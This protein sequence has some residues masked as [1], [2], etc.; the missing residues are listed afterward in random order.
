M[1]Y[2]DIEDR[3]LPGNLRFL[4]TELLDTQKYFSK[5]IKEKVL[6]TTAKVTRYSLHTAADS[7]FFTRACACVCVSAG[8]KGT[9]L[10]L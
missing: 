2:V 9:R 4:L 1:L 6:V 3:D 7:Y 5:K 10:R 8:F